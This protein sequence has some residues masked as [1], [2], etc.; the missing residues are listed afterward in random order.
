MSILPLRILQDAVA[1]V[2]AV[3]YAAGV[4]GIAAAV[5]IVASF[6]LGPAVAVL[7][8]IVMLGLMAALLAFARAA[9]V[10]AESSDA[11]ADPAAVRRAGIV[12]V[13][14]FTLLICATGVMMFTMTFFGTPLTWQEL[15]RSGHVSGRRT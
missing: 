2:P 10:G 11:A 7:G 8:T 13:W 3:R 9:R 6:T 12:L 1:A 5:A 15:L 4:A 14:V